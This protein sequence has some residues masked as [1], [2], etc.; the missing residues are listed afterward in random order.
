MMVASS[1]GRSIGR[2]IGLVLSLGVGA[3]G[4]P[5]QAQV[6]TERNL[7]WE[8]TG[9]DLTNPSY[10]YGTIHIAC[11]NEVTPNAVLKQKFNSTQQLYLELDFDD[12]SLRSNLVGGMALPPGKN[13]R[14]YLKQ[15]DYEVV[16]QFF[17]KSLGLPLDQLS[18]IKPL[19]LSSMAIPAL[20]S[21]PIGSWETSLT[22]LA[23]SQKLPIEGLETVQEQVALFDK[24]PLGAQVQS[25]LDMARN[26]AKTKQELR[27]LHEQYRSQ[28]LGLMAGAFA[29][30]PVMKPYE[31]AFLGDRNRRWVPKMVRVAKGKPT[32]FAV[33]AGHLGGKDGVIALLRRS[34]YRVRAVP[35]K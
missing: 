14:S 32:F 35:L 6:P 12:P 30:E 27:M 1:V 25:L 4:L 29:R 7:L 16:S 22:E 9:K 18:T 17:E 5:G 8:I 15:K 3:I 19:F 34:G 13:L 21:C 2:S 10:L 31:A 24:I 26:P 28:D 11:A 23:Q 33:G 20:H